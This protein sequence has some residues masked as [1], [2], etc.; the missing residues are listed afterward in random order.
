MCVECALPSV[1]VNVHGEGIFFLLF[2]IFQ[3]SIFILISIL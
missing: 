2:F 3:V 1:V